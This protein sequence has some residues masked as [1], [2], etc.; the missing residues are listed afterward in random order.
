MHWNTD[1][2]LVLHI[3]R[4]HLHLYVYRRIVYIYTMYICVQTID[5]YR[6]VLDFCTVNDTI[7]TE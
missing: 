5:M 3:Q 2:N 6:Y 7:F 1:H 4:Q